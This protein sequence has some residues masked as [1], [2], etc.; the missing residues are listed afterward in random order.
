M[1]ILSIVGILVLS[2]VAGACKSTHEEGVKSN[3]RSQ[4][5][6]VMADTKATTA[7]AQAILEAEGLK[8]IKSSS[9]NVDGTASGKKADG[10]VVKVAVKKKTETSSDVSVTVGTIGDPTMGANF[11]RR[12]KDKAEGR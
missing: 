2:L 1:K 3:L 8:D 9:T 11:A 4:W 6:N 5:T 10:T 12:I 7:A